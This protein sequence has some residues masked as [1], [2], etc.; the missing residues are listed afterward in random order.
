MSAAYF[1]GF[2]LNVLFTVQASLGEQRCRKKRVFSPNFPQVPLSGTRI[3]THGA[4]P[5]A[6][7]LVL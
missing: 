1:L 3:A 2:A 7:M 5:F 6:L 4:P